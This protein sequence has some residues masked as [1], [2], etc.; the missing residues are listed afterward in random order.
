L[1]ALT[2]YILASR[3]FFTALCTLTACLHALIH[4]ADLFAAVCTR[5]AYLGACR[6]HHVMYGRIA[7]H[8]IGGGLT[9]FRT[10]EHQSEML[11]FDMLAAFLQA[12]CHCH[13]QANVVTSFARV[14]TSLHFR[15]LGSLKC[16]HDLLKVKHGFYYLC[17]AS[18]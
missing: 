6:A 1:L 5:I 11:F 17:V 4:I 16:H 13:P 15:V 14:N 3:H 8:E 18:H 9:N 2:A 12:M 10:V 7:Q